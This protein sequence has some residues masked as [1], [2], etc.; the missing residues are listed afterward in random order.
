MANVNAGWEGWAGGR[1]CVVPGTTE[2]EIFQGLEAKAWEKKN[3]YGMAF[4]SETH[5]RLLVVG[6]TPQGYANTPDGPKTWRT[7]IE[8]DRKQVAWYQEFIAPRPIDSMT[9]QRGYKVGAARALGLPDDSFCGL[10]YA[11][12]GE[13]FT[14]WKQHTGNDHLPYEEV[15][16]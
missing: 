8:G 10:S 9:F 6:Y 11:R 7:I 5:H 13:F 1:L 2:E 16:A 12:W 3:T 4:D 14:A 15:R